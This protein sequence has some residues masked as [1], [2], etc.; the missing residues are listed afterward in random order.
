MGIRL[1]IV[2]FTLTLL[3]MTAAPARSRAGRQPSLRSARRI[4]SR[5]AGCGCAQRAFDGSG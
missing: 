4:F 3:F 1:C 5:G 2:E